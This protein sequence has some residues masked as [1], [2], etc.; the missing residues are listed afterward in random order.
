MNIIHMYRIND[1]L[2]NV[3]ST[4]L[5]FPLSARKTNNFRKITS[6]LFI[7]IICGIEY[8]DIN[9]TIKFP[10]K[11]LNYIF[12]LLVLSQIHIKTRNGIVLNDIANQG[13][14]SK[15]CLQAIVKCGL[16]HKTKTD[17]L[18]L[19]KNRIKSGQIYCRKYVSRCSSLK[20]AGLFTILKHRTVTLDIIAFMNI[21]TKY[22]HI[23]SFYKC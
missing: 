2:W 7:A 16:K 12:S 4:I 17:C 6:P 9:K 22:R 21:L 13:Q 18:R 8:L 11:F 23:C 15:I 14:I 1:Q 19:N 5:V 10:L 20:F 3:Q